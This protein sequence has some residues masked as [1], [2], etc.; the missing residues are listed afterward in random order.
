MQKVLIAVDESKGSRSVL[1]VHRTMIQEPETVV[2]IH[3][4]RPSSSSVI[5][6]LPVDPDMQASWRDEVRDERSARIIRFYE[7]ELEKAGPLRIKTLVREGVPSEEILRAAREESVDL[8]VMGS[9]SKPVFKQFVAGSTVKQV[10]RGTTIPVLAANISRCKKSN[11]CCWKE[12]E[13]YAA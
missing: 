4:Q 3:V 5:S 12:R 11:E 13:T 6:V 10:E 9:I 1:S 8:I 7:Q 2:L